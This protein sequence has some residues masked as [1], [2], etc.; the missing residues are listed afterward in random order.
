MDW[1]VLACW[2]VS[3]TGLCRSWLVHHAPPSSQQQCLLLTL[4][5]KSQ[6]GIAG[7]SRVVACP[8]Q[9]C[10]PG[11]SHNIG[12]GHLHMS[13]FP[14][15]ATAVKTNTLRLGPLVS[16]KLLMLTS[17]PYL[18]ARQHGD[19]E[20]KLADKSSSLGRSTNSSP[21]PSKPQTPSLK[22]ASCAH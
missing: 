20:V 1:T 5:G 14:G 7:C 6:G 19:R 18:E 11:N 17:Y 21:T 9:V 16:N 3:I 10:V 15:Q 8:R 4:N 2:T 22:I 13:S 12:K